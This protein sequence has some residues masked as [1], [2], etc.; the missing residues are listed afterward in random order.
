MSDTPATDTATLHYIFDPL[1]GWCYAA[2][3]LLQAARTLPGLAIA[4]HGGGMLAGSNRRPVTPQWRAHVLPHDQ[5]IAAL[6]GQPFGDAYFDGLLRDTGAVLDSAPPTTAILAAEALAGRGPEMLARQQRAHYVEGRRIADAAVL[7]AL[8]ADIGL[9]PQAFAAQSAALAGAPT[10]AHVADS[11]QWLARVGGHG[12][13]TLALARGPQ[14]KLL[15]AGAWLG[16]PEAWRA[17][18]ARQL[19]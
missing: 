5:R 16:R 10:Q 8:A 11:R 17:E 12:F 6:S 19:A 13:P 4:L 7:Q 2:A 18:L 9:D 14:L 3:P 15:D 1:C